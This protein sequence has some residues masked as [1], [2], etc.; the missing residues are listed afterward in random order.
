MDFTKPEVRQAAI[1]LSRHPHALL[2][3]LESGHW[4]V[5][6]GK[7]TPFRRRWFSFGL[8]TSSQMETMVDSLVHHA[9][10]Q[11]L[12]EAVTEQ[13]PWLPDIDGRLLLEAISIAYLARLERDYTVHSCNPAF[14]WEAYAVARKASLP[15]PEWVLA[16][17]DESARRVTASIH[18][19]GG[20]AAEMFGL[21]APGGGK[22]APVGRAHRIRKEERR[23]ALFHKK[24]NA[25]SGWADKVTLG[26]ADTLGSNRTSVRVH[27]D[28]VRDRIMAYLDQR[29][30]GWY[31]R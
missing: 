30:P 20:N 3:V 24:R 4:T 6:S 7:L 14:A 22:K 12:L 28:A 29:L 8:P 25:K 19:P 10:I 9:A 27:T 16:Y 11:S 17:L 23:F 2:S 31:R 21:A 15:V 26:A 13:A 18:R 1:W 5:E